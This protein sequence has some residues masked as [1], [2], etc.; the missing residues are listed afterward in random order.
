MQYSTRPIETMKRGI[1]IHSP[2]TKVM[3]ML[4]AEPL[5]TPFVTTEEDVIEKPP[6]LEPDRPED[7]ADVAA[8]VVDA[9][10]PTEPNPL[11]TAEPAT[12]EEKVIA[13]TSSDDFPNN[14]SK[15]R[16]SRS[17][18]AKR[19]GTSVDNVILKPTLILT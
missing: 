17:T 12:N 15:S 11:T 7:M 9:L 18:E 3:L 14:F 8:T 5:S 19:V 6:T 13:S 4:L 1:P 2:M 10:P 16:T